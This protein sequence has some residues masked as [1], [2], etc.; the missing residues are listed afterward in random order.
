MTMWK[1]R[2][3]CSLRSLLITALVERGLWYCREERQLFIDMIDRQLRYFL[4]SVVANHYRDQ[5]L[6]DTHSG[7]ASF[8]SD[9]DLISKS[10]LYRS[11][12][13][14]IRIYD[15][16]MKSCMLMDWCAEWIELKTFPIWGRKFHARLNAMCSSSRSFARRLQKFGRADLQSFDNRLSRREIFPAKNARWPGWGHCDLIEG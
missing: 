4:T 11:Y 16:V 3:R 8:W 5:F 9:A 12:V 13:L 6:T 1:R 14:K 2:I 10:F 7:P 15:L